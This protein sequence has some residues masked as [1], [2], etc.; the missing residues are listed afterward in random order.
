MTQIGVKEAELVFLGY[1]DAGLGG[2]YAAEG[3]VPFRQRSTQ[4]S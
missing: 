2:V 1:P 3:S 4:K